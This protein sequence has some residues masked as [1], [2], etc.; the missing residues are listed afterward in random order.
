MKKKDFLKGCITALAT[1]FENGEIDY[2]SLADL[3]D[4]QCKKGSSDDTVSAILL[5]GTTG[6][7]PTLSDK[8]RLSLFSFAAERSTLPVMAGV[9]SNDTRHAAALAREAEKFSPYA[10]LVVSPYYNKAN[11][12]GLLK[13]FLTVAEVSL[14]P[15][16]VYNVPTRTAVDIPLSVY[17]KLA[18]HENIVGVKEASPDIAKSLRLI[19]GDKLS[20]FAGNDDLALPSILC[21]ADGV[22][23]VASNLAPTKMA[24][25]CRYASSGR[26]SE[27]C[28]LAAELTP[29][30]EFLFSDVNPIPLKYALSRIGLC[31]NS[32]RLPLS[33]LCKEKEKRL[34][35]LIHLFG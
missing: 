14:S 18:E 19:F 3:I 15:V 4:F 16:I 1:P 34:D 26:V 35:E 11:P 12:D 22:I 31:E 24:R 21:G 17:E 6:E 23:S 20:V 5:S 33:P 8:E 13:H 27:A 30:F 2:A 25:L 10:I 28:A 7:S 29:L 32:L 9:G